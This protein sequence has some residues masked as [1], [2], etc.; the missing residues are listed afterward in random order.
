MGSFS[1]FHLLILAALVL[2]FIAL[3]V[4]LLGWFFS[5]STGTEKDR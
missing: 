5:F 3:P 1:L 2:G 4:L